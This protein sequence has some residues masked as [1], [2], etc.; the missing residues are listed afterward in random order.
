ME[1]SRVRALRGPNLWSRQTA[2]QAIVSCLPHEEDIHALPGFETRLRA[3][4]PM[5][6]AL[7]PT[8]CGDSRISLAHALES[9]A[10]HLQ[11]QAGCPVT[12]SR[13]VPTLERGV[14]QIVAQYSEEEVGRLALELAEEIISATLNDTPFDAAA[15]LARLRDLDEDV[16]LGPSTGSIV[17]A[18]VARDVPFRRLTGGSLVQFGWGSKQR[19][20][21]A[22]ETDMS[23][24]IAE[25]IAQDK[26]LTKELL[27]AAGVP[28]PAGR[29]VSDGDAAWTAAEAIGLPVVIKPR[30]G[31]Q[32]K[33]VA[34]N[35]TSR[36]EVL[37]AFAVA[38]DICSDVIVERYLP[39]QDYRVLVVG[40]KMVA[41]ARREPP[42]V[43]GDGVHSIRELVE[44]VNRDPRRGEGHAT[45]LTKIRFDDI[46]KATLAAQGLDAGT[47]PVLGQRVVL[48]NNANLST[49]G[50]A[51]DVTDDV[52]PDLAA[53]AVAAAQMVGLDICGVDI[54]CETV[55]RSL[56]DQGGGIVEVNAAPGLRMHL[57]PSFGK[58][59]DVGAAIIGNMFA[60][61]DNGRIPVVAVSGTNG[62]TTTVRLSAH[63]IAQTGKRMGMTVTDGVY[64]N[65]RQIDSGDCSGPRSARNVLMHPDVDAAVFETARGGMLR[66][67]L[68]FDRCDVAV[69]TNVGEGDHLGLNYIYTLDE[70]AV[71]KSIVV[72][73]VSP[74]GMAVLNAAD[75]MVARMAAS[76]PGSVTFFAHDGHHP[77]INAHRAQGRRVIYV[78]DGQIVCA[79]GGDVRMTFDLAQ[80]PLTAGGRIAFQIEN[81]MGAVGAA[82]ALGIAQEQIAAGLASFVSDAATAPGRFNLFDY[83]GATL[84]ADYGHNPDAMQALVQAVETLPGQRRIVVIS[85]AGDRRDEDIRRQTRILGTAFDEVVLYQDA[86]QRGRADGEVV[87]LLREGLE[88]APRTRQI[89]EIQ[90]EFL[91]ID[92]ALA[93]LA[94]GDL[95]LILVDQVEEALAH[96]QSRCA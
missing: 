84:I 12:F 56:E 62:K 66:E 73:N 16:R 31:N 80:V 58:G 14:Y 6:G 82:W 26:D 51:T 55:R 5:A 40:D 42:L 76:C 44:E 32:G 1:V 60:G 29:I 78:E 87:A 35:L 24:A 68:G 94:P 54:V 88:G 3:R 36:D 65:G 21:Q 92:T 9:V 46:A 95:C 86:C 18:A 13:T 69:V 2:I 72:Q 67:G 91:A 27:A 79:E 48:R 43:I 52:H 41:A 85:G 34:V 37:A 77:V 10:L 70:L 33:G 74:S 83:R 57:Q 49:G 15:A 63:L 39:G 71:L 50:S 96:I 53:S 17:D 28:V 20:I 30:D 38:C 45:S 25:A 19:R 47:V 23:S 11:I 75:P 81:S 4:F 64:V 8:A 93:R 89:D 90:G 22:A 59:R 7:L 61:D